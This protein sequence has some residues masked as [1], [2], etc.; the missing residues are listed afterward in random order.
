MADRLAEAL[1]RGTATDGIVI[2]VVGQWGSGKTSLLN[3]TRGAIDKREEADR[4]HLIEFKPWLVG[5]RDSLLQSLFI[6][7]AAGLDQIE[8]K[9]GDST[10][11]TVS[12]T[13]SAGAAVR[14]FASNL[15]GVATAAKT[16]GLVIPWV[17]TIGAFVGGAAK[18]ASGKKAPSLAR[19]K[20]RVSKRLQQL[21]RP[22]IVVV[23]DLDRL[24]PK[25]IVEVLRLVRSVADFPNVIYVLGYDQEIVAHAVESAALVADGHAYME[26]IVQITVPV[27]IPE[28][29]ELRRWFRSELQELA[30]TSTPEEERRITE[31]ID[32][33]GGRYLTTPRSVIRTSDSIRFTQAAVKD[34]V[35]LTDLVWLQLVK[36][37]NP[38]LYAWTEAYITEISARS[39]GRVHVSQE[40]IE[41]SRQQ[42][43]RALQREA[44]TFSEVC[45]RLAPFLPGITS[46]QAGDS[47]EA[48]IFEDVSDQ[49]VD[50]AVAGRR[51]AS[52]DHYRRFFTFAAPTNA[53]VVSDYENFVEVTNDSAAAT[54]QLLADWQAQKLTSGVS[55]TEVMLDRLATDAE[56]HL[57]PPRAR[58]LL[59]AFAEVLD[60]LGREDVQDLGGPDV[61]LRADRLMPRLL[62]IVGD[63]RNEILVLMFS[64]GRAVGWLT[65]ILRTETFGHGR[66]GDRPTT[67]HILTDGEL[68]QISAVMVNRYRT[69][70]FE[71]IAELPQPLSALFGWQQ[72]GDPDGPRSLLESEAETNEGLIKVLETLSGLVRSHSRNG[73][74]ETTTLSRGNL[75]GM[76]EYDEVRARIETLAAQTDIDED[77]RR[78]AEAVK[79]SFRHAERF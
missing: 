40:G 21:P 22:L 5:D 79:R 62:E 29:F 52:P 36:V 50:H 20:R 78:R 18:A 70:S 64:E 67:D 47:N 43:N 30:L 69:M 25:E 14:D 57:T 7:L 54:A 71:Q 13:K 17:G 72:A 68:D 74:R 31:I 41:R 15:G 60:D 55:K 28:A 63:T 38:A 3:L 35:D 44:Q 19:L 76:L 66:V 10:N 2:G 34:T 4:P 58:H 45:G 12:K 49:E 53:P 75:S 51:L 46:Y 73:L 24:E 8:H 42:L 37:G 6:E 48:G 1:S 33:D 32:V 56:A 61:W 65:S 9:A 23:D 27:P 26:K 77:L 59:L 16:I 11:L 39:I